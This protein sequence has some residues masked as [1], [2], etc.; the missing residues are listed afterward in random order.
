MD[1]IAGAVIGGVVIAV[2]VAVSL[3]QAAKDEDET[4]NE[5]I[6]EKIEK[7][8]SALHQNDDERSE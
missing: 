5:L 3:A 2:A 7:I 8:K 1:L 6:A 4:E